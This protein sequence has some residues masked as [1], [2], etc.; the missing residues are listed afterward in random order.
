MKFYVKILLKN[1]ISFVVLFIMFGLV[2]NNDVIKENPSRI[3]FWIF[4]GAGMGLFITILSLILDRI[5][6]HWRITS[7]RKKPLKK[8]FPN[9]NLGESETGLSG[10]FEGFPI[11]IS[12]NI[13][14]YKRIPHRGIQINISFSTVSS[15]ILY[16]A[17]KELPQNLIHTME[18]FYLSL[19]IPFRELKH[20]LKGDLS[21]LLQKTI[22]KIKK[23]L[24]PPDKNYCMNC[25]KEIKK[26]K[27]LVINDIVVY[28]CTEC[29]H[30]L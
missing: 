16:E 19:F 18:N 14:P 20:N 10:E 5:V 9:I 29:L 26:S 30:K 24:F 28:L 25:K 7:N 22:S 11:F 23:H 12:Y 3:F 1:I 21:I 15:E 27:P 4:M 17:K 2:F 8:F 6:Y 13:L